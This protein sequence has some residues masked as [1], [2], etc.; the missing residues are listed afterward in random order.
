MRISFKSQITYAAGYKYQLRQTYEVAVCVTPPEG[1]KL[2]FVELSGM[3]LLTIRRGYAWDG[4]S[5][6]GIDTKSIMRGSLVHDALYQ[7]MREGEIPLSCR[8]LADKELRRIC[9]EDGMWK[10]RAWWVYRGVRRGAGFAAAPRNKRKELRA[11]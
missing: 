5:G 10:V 1:V 4:A 7:L 3:G 11:P 6:P 9:L 8:E 2:E